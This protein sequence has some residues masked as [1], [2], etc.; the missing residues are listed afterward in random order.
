MV[1]TADQNATLDKL[2][3]QLEGASTYLGSPQAQTDQAKAYTTPTTTPPVIAAD[4][5]KN[6]A[7]PMT[8][9][10][11]TPTS[12]DYY[13]NLMK[14]IPTAES[15]VTQTSPDQDDAKTTQTSLQ[16]KILDAI[17]SMGGKGVAQSTAE[18]N[19]GLPDMEKNLTDVTSQITALQNE[20]Q[21]IPLDVQN[22]SRGRGRTDAGVAP[23][24]AD[25]LRENA[26]K[27]LSLS[28][29][30]STLRGNISTAQAEVDRAI[31]A[32]FDPLQSELDYLKQAYTFN[33]DAMT[34]ADKAQADKINAKLQDR[35]DQLDQD[36]ADRTQLLQYVNSAVQA[37][38]PAATATKALGMDLTGALSLLQPYLKTTSSSLVTIL[39]NAAAAGAPQV[40][41]D[42]AKAT[43]DPVQAAS[44]LNKYVYKTGE[45]NGVPSTFTFTNDQRSQL[46]SGGFTGDDVTK[47]QADVAKYGLDATVK[48]MADNGTS[49]V[50]QDLIKRVLAKTDAVNDVTTDP[51]K[52]L[53][54][55]YFGTLFTDQQLQTA[56]ADAGY[57]HWYTTWSAE[58]AAYLQ[59]LMDTVTQYRTAGYS[60]QE[61]LKMMQ[62]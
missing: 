48:N 8:M 61:I 2:K 20:A 5:L 30:A 11:Y 19:A 3:Q 59:H 36:K 15:T 27:A 6:P 49:Q 21:A 55:D 60:D 57:R 10:T 23:I 33:S 29:I 38:A 22:E 28:S 56:A 37:G 43:N 9:P 32:Q 58:K 16:S 44:I 13:S 47:I 17:K 46:L 26:I 25:R 1:L 7:T 54:T 12:P 42:Q 39:T 50:Q 14:S 53:T 24:T 41:L 51:K 62:G 31:A 35:Q 18:T 52:F 34:A 40:L 45:N 4:G